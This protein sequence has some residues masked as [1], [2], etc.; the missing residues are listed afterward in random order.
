MNGIR[1]L[2]T[3]GTFDKYYDELTGELTFKESHLPAVLRQARVT[4]HIVLEINQLVDSSAMEDTHRQDILSACAASPET[5]II[6]IH[7]TDTM[8]LTAEVLGKAALP[9]TVVLTGAMI[10]YTMRGSDAMFNLGYAIAA[11]QHLPTGVY[12]AMN[13]QT[14]LWNTVRKNREQGVFERID[15]KMGGTTN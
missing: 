2:V 13:G 11:A 15:E 4:A 3:G 9:K 7:G 6:I 14:F 5:H 1:I 12:I 10:P 8:T